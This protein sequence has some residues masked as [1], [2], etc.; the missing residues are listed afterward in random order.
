MDIKLTLIQVS[1]SYVNLDWIQIPVVAGAVFFL[2]SLIRPIIL[3]IFSDYCNVKKERASFKTKAI[4]NY[5]KVI[6]SQFSN[7]DESRY[8]ESIFY[9]DSLSVIR[10]VSYSLKPYLKVKGWSELEALMIE[11]SSHHVSEFDGGR[12][13]LAAVFKTSMGSGGIHHYD[14]LRYYLERFSDIVKEL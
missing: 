13:R 7:L 14:L 10:G 8:N 12:D 1:N 9:R 3:R 11:Y 4:D 6:A 5:K 2:V